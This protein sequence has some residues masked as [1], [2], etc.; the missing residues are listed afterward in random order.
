MLLQKSFINKFIDKETGSMAVVKN[1]GMSER[2]GP[3]VKGVFWLDKCEDLFVKIVSF[4]EIFGKL[5]VEV[6]EVDA[7]RDGLDTELGRKGVFGE[8][9]KHLLKY[10]WRSKSNAGFKTCKDRAVFLR[11]ILGQ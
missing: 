3:S 8:V 7:A 10:T 6:R 11:H 9:G 5:S 4:E 1:Q 2:F